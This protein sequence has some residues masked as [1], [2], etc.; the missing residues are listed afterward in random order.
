MTSV[1]RATADSNFL[2]AADETGE[3]L[4]FI[5]IYR[6]VNV[7]IQMFSV[8][9]YCFA[10]RETIERQVYCHVDAGTAHRRQIA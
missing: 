8:S 2:T 4:S 1:T 10:N 3:H 6:N 9:S 7:S 5:L